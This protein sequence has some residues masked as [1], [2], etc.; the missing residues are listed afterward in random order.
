MLGTKCYSTAIDVW[1]IGCV[2]AE[3]IGGGHFLAAECEIGQ[4][5]KIFECF[6]TPS[7]DCELASLPEFKMT[8]PKFHAQP[9]SKYIRGIEPLEVDLLEKMLRLSPSK[10]ISV[11]ECLNH[12]YFDGMNKSTAQ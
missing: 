11:D 1:S 7:Q 2:F 8:F 6:G 3:I 12:K 10:R 5:F 9:L 4:L